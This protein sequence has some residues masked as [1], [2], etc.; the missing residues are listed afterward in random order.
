MIKMSL[1]MKILIVIV[2]LLL[3]IFFFPKPG[4]GGTMHAGG[5]NCKCFG[6]EKELVYM[7]GSRTTCY[8]IPYECYHYEPIQWNNPK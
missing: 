7:G 3:V 4:G 8:G 1:K 2:V 5:T 6:L